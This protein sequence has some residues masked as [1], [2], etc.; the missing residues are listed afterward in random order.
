MS[1]MS[2]QLNKILSLSQQTVFQI[3]PLNLTEWFAV[4]CFSLPVILL[5]ELLKYMSRNL[6]KSSTRKMFKLMHGGKAYNMFIL[7]HGGKAYN[8]FKLLHGGKA[9]FK[10]AEVF[11]N[12][13][14]C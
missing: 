2:S 10:R 1:V 13:F 9:Y 14:V 4:L 6:G 8:I 3:T 11:V 12:L 7:M 5:D